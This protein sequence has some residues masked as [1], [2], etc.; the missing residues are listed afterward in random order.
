MKYNAKK[1]E[2]ALWQAKQ[3]ELNRIEESAKKVPGVAP[4]PATQQ[5]SFQEKLA[6]SIIRNLQVQVRNIHVRYEDE[7]TN[8]SNPF[9][10]G[11]TLKG[12]DFKVS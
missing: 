5:D 7:F 11:I 6:S 12:L 9:S 2:E 10:A 8:P 3:K 1:E 4:D